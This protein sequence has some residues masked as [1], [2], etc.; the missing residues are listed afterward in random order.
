MKRILSV[1]IILSAASLSFAYDEKNMADLVV[2]QQIAPKSL[3]INI[4][5][6]FLRTTSADFPDNFITYANVDFA[7][8]Y[9]L[10][11]KLEIGTGLTLRSWMSWILSENTFPSLGRETKRHPAQVLWLIVFQSE[12]KNQLRVITSCFPFQTA[13][14]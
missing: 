6:R 4:T 5:H 3:E 10:W 7:L 1:F 8:R 11:S 14:I 12:L 2:P 13:L 9:A